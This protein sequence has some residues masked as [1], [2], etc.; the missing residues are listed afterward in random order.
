MKNV[1]CGIFVF[2]LI[3]CGAVQMAWAQSGD[4]N[5]GRRLGLGDRELV[6]L[7]VNVNLPERVEAPTRPRPER[8]EPTE[9]E[10]PDW[11]KEF[12]K[13]YDTY[14]MSVAVE[15]ALSDNVSSDDIL[16]FIISRTEKF[17]RKRGLKALYCSGVDRNTVR[18][19]ANKLGIT[20]E[21]VS[22]SLE[23]AIAEC[24]SKLTLEDRDLM[25]TPASSQESGTGAS[26]ITEE[27]ISDPGDSDNPSSPAR[28]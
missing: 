14:G 10:I 23:E 24:G 12:E 19:A 20:V 17:K 9:P 4:E 7:P 27:F 6:P 16:T 21:E 15:E 11:M 5:R 13:N 26:V 25:E 2:I 1:L 22:L 18:D 8:T 28:P 3:G